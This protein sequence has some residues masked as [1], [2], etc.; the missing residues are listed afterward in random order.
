MTT[1]LIDMAPAPW[2]TEGAC[3]DEDP[4]LFFP[5]SSSEASA[6]RARAICDGCQVRDECLRYALTNRIKDGIWGGRTEQQ[7]QSLIRA[8]RR[9]R[10]KVRTRP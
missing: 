3:Q 6:E 2:M 1:T 10:L 8:R 5:I 7:R 9:R 4:E